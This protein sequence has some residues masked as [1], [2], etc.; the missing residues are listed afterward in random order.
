MAFNKEQQQELA[1]ATQKVLDSNEFQPVISDKVKTIAYFATDSAAIASGFIFTV[2]A[3]LHVVDGIDAITITTA[4]TTALL[5]LKQTF[6]LSSKK[7]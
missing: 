2:L 1:I 6:R 4:I 5:G 3:I 7:Q